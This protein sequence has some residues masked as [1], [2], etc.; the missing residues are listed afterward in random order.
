M[1][2]PEPPRCI[3]AIALFRNTPLATLE[4]ALGASLPTRPRRVQAGGAAI[5]CLAPSRYVV[6][7]ARGSSLP[8]RLVTDLAGAAAVTDQSDQWTIFALSGPAARDR[9]AGVVPTDVD[10]TQ[11]RPGD[12]A[13]TRAGHLDVRLWRLDEERY[14]I[15]V[16]RSLADDLFFVLSQV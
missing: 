13:L 11:F 3:T 14:E 1:V 8:A 4:R 10:D 16:L 2:E 15:A 9:L 6:M 5:S 12:V 7:T